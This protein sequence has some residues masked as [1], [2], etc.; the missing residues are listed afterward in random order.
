MGVTSIID[1]SLSIFSFDNNLVGILFSVDFVVEETCPSRPWAVIRKLIVFIWI[2]K[3]MKNNRSLHLR[4]YDTKCKKGF[5]QEVSRIFFLVFSSSHKFP[6][7]KVLP[8]YSHKWSLP[9]F[10]QRSFWISESSYWN[11]DQSS[12]KDFRRR[13]SWGL[14]EV[15]KVPPCTNISSRDQSQSIFSQMSST[16]K[17]YAFVLSISVMLPAVA[18]R[19]TD[20][21]WK[22]GD[23][24]TQEEVMVIRHE[25]IWYNF[26]LFR[27]IFRLNLFCYF[28]SLLTYLSLIGDLRETVP[29]FHS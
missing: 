15:F 12:S 21:R 18:N 20:G 8:I 10:F 19:E 23:K 7:Q 25:D 16:F 14:L 26:A 24:I 4:P 17:K 29:V 9:I 11:F 27:E 22:E 6:F 1:F 5:F 3:S 13:F 28:F 2:R